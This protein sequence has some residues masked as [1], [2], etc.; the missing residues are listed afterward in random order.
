MTKTP[1][2]CVNI[3]III[4]FANL[5]Q[6][7]IYMEVWPYGEEWRSIYLFP[8]SMDGKEDRTF[9]I[10]VIAGQYVVGKAGTQNK[11]ATKTWD[12]GGG[13]HSNISFGFKNQ[14]NHSNLDLW[15]NKKRKS[16]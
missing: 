13:E 8:S 3:G 7:L 16:N 2:K 4:V 1:G 12:E 14:N 6:N 5:M 10:L 15:R 11:L 9:A